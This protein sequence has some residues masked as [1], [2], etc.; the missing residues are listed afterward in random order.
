MFEDTVRKNKLNEEFS[1]AISKGNLEKIKELFTPLK[2]Y[3]SICEKGELNEDEL[4]KLFKDVNKNIPFINYEILTTSGIMFAAQMGKWD[5]VIELFNLNADIDVRIE[6]LN[7]YFVQEC[8]AKAP[9]NILYPVLDC[10][11]LNVKTKN[12]ETPLMTAIKK[13]KDD[14]SNYLLNH[15]N[16]IIDYSI[17]DNDL[18]NYA[19]YAAKHE[20]YDLLLK[21]V[22]KGVPILSKNKNGE[23]P[24]DLIQDDIFRMTLPEKLEKISASGKNVVFNIDGSKK[25][26]KFSKKEDK[27]TEKEKPRLKGLSVIN[28]M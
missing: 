3:E 13:N 1:I 27:S 7:W 25:V 24:I 19:H 22:E 11:N 18:N 14:V 17:C 9:D 28:R 12:G 8:I 15:Q 10:A 4:N 20:K 26:A 23:T 21:L 2:E 5:I 16:I 6:P